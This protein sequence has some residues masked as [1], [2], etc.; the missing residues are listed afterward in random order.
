MNRSSLV[1]MDRKA[2]PALADDVD[3]REVVVGFRLEVLSE[4]DVCDWEHKKRTGRDE[5][6]F[7]VESVRSIPS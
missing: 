7:P 5:L 2:L 3:V 6:C 1:L 4:D